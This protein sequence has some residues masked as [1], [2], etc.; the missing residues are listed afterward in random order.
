[1]KVKDRA[2]TTGQRVNS[3]NGFFLINEVKFKQFIE[4]EQVEVISYQTVKNQFM[5]DDGLQL[6][7]EDLLSDKDLLTG[8]LWCKWSLGGKEGVLLRHEDDLLGCND[9]RI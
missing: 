1:M 9:R 8:R 6:S 7:E 2:F 4:F 5:V 3:K